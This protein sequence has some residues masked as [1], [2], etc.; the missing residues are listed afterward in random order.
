MTIWERV[1]T[2]LTP[3]NVPMAAS[4]YIPASG[5]SLPDLY[6]VYSL[7]SNPP[8][9]HADNAET[10]QMYRIQVSCFCRNGL[11]TIPDIRGAMVSAGFIRAGAVEIPFSQET[12][13]YG[14]ALD[15]IYQE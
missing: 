8:V 9:Q 3:L 7:I 13:H 15:F 14:L 2:A 5:Q 4:I 11:N 10:M 12:G 1:T 6:L